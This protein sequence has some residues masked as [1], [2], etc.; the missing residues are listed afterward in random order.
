MGPTS[1]FNNCFVG[2]GRRRD[3]SSNGIEPSNIARIVSL[4]S[5]GGRNCNNSRAE[6]D[7]NIIEQTSPKVNHM[8]VYC[9]YKVCG[10]SELLVGKEILQE[11][12][13]VEGVYLIELQYV[14][15]TS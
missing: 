9:I 5:M 3:R 15:R 6:R 13:G 11:G 7:S 2:V 1:T 12:R 4:L 14:G 10:A 8:V